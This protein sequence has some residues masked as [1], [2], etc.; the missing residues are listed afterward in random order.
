[1]TCTFGPVEG[2]ERCSEKSISKMHSFVN[3]DDSGHPLYVTNAN[4]LHYVL[5]RICEIFQLR[6]PALQIYPMRFFANAE[7]S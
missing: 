5:W 3:E 2:S 7:L 1:V 4:D 6:Y